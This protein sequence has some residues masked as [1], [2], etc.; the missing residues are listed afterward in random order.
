M[1]AGSAN[2]RAID[3]TSAFLT[4]GQGGQAT[5]CTGLPTLQKRAWAI[6]VTATGYSA[7]GHLTIEPRWEGISSSSFMNFA[8][9]AYAIANAGTV[10]AVHHGC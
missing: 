2:G 9:G 4:E 10:T 7:P 6:N 3:L 8:P 5:A 1:G